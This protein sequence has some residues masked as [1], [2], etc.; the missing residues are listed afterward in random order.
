MQT[1]T[2]NNDTPRNPIR[3]VQFG[4]GNFLRAFVDWMIQ[5]LNDTAAYNA[6]VAVV[7]PLPSGLVHLLA[8]QDGIYHHVRQGIE[9]GQIIDEIK[10][11]TCISQC[12]NPF[13]DFESYLHLAQEPHLELIFSNTTEAG[14]VFEESDV[15]PAAKT[16]AQTFP[17]KLTQLLKSRFD[18]FEG[19]IDKGVSIIPCELIENNGTKLRECVQAY[20]E[21]WQLG[22]Q[23]VTWLNTACSFAN[24]LVDRIVPGYPREEVDTLTRRIGEDDQ[25]LV[26]SEAFHLFVIEADAR[27]RK[28]FPA[29]QHGLNVKYVNDITPYR[30]QKV[31]ILNGAH[32]S[33]V[34][35]GL[36]NHLETVSE[37]INDEETGKLVREIIFD[38]IVPTIHIPGE[39][40]A[41]FANAVIARF[42]NPFIRHELISISLNS[43]S[44]FKVRVLPTLLDYLEQQGTLP[45]RLTF[46]LACLIRLY[47]EG[48]FPLKDEP[49][50]LEFFAGLCDKNAAEK[51]Q[52]TLANEAF[53]E[54]D[55]TQING[56]TQLVTE[57]LTA[58]TSQKMET[59]LQNF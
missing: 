19:E 51:V 23:F 36:L 41:E 44:K 7:Q 26:K 10:R 25:L 31:R 58:I 12:V 32:T 11:I 29:D 47:S 2:R 48:Q 33:M 28:A 17:G 22:N 55:L 49:A 1:L 52:L 42:Q 37:T 27:I 20:A 15:L 45:N 34:P 40:P 14:I 35:V 59:V 4:E 8:A 16:P 30:T 6:G 53:W 38:E 50:N 9:N 5:H 56:L 13:V 46:S 57:H 24:T 3:I 39:D 18:H 21:H 54:Q 43:I